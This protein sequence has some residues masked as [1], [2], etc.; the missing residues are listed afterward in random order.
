MELGSIL[1]RHLD[2]NISGFSVFIAGSTISTPGERIQKVPDSP[3]NL[4]D[5]CTCGRMVY[6]ERK[7]CGFKN[8]R[9]CVDAA[10]ILAHL[11]ILV[12]LRCFLKIRVD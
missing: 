6:P 8:I 10:L 4:P 1:F 2:K 11:S 5:T 9:L 3:A 7:S 12:F